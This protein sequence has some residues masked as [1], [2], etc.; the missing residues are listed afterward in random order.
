[1]KLT[2]FFSKDCLLPCLC[3]AL[4]LIISALA[5]NNAAAERYT[6]PGGGQIVTLQGLPLNLTQFNAK[7]NGYIPD[8][9]GNDFIIMEQF[10]RNC[11]PNS[12]Q[13]VLYYYRNH[14]RLKDIWAAGDI[15]TVALGTWPDELRRALNELD[16]PTHW[17]TE[18]TLDDVRRYIRN[19]RPPILLLRLSNT[20]YHW[21]VAVGYDTQSDK[22][23]IADPQ[24]RF[25]WWASAELQ[26]GW[27]LRWQPAFENKEAAWYEFQIDVGLFANL[28]L[29]PNTVVVPLESPSFER[30]YHPYWTDMQAIEIYGSSG[31]DF[32][33]ETRTWEETVTFDN[34]FVL[35]QVSDIELVSS[36]ATAR[37]DG[38]ERVGDSSIRLWGEVG[39]GFVLH[40]R[41]WV[42]VRTFYF[43]NGAAAPAVTA[44]LTTATAL[45]PNYPNPFNP[46]TWIPY[47][48]ASPADVAVSIYAADG[49]LVRTLE[50]GYQPAGIYQSRSRAAHWDGRNAQ[51]ERVA[52]GVYFYTFTAGDF[53]A[54]GKMLVRK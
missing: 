31:N 42:I 44:P 40:G 28:T 11:G 41:M 14:R 23:L 20:G 16:V 25:Q 43:N 18:K 49:K 13:M 24:G 12:V 6:Y 21:V 4:I 7:A 36:T 51:G 47:Q 8:K 54:T 39:D 48:L 52:S 2:S 22:F 27:D 35:A 19:N 1:M 45:L 38:W 9:G 53:T 3:I 5:S 33:R 50:L 32:W 37:L 17:Y 10:N 46:E 15:H 26:A 34:P 30:G 29:K